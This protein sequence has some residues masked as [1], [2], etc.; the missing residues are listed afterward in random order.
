MD[1]KKAIGFLDANLVDTGNRVRCRPAGAA[2][3]LAELQGMKLV[4]LPVAPL[5]QCFWW[6]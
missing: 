5:A 3:E 4:G 1:G 2:S 6:R